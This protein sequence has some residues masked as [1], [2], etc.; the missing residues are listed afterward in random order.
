MLRLLLI[1]DS[2]ARDAR[3]TRVQAK[4]AE[5]NVTLAFVFVTGAGLATT[6]GSAFVFCTGLAN[7]KMLAGALGASAGVMLYVRALLAWCPNVRR[8]RD[9]L[10]PRVQR[11]VWLAAEDPGWVDAASALL[12]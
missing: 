8:G 12:V 11:V 1:A 2:A 10:H 7:H 6:I 5:G 3:G 4:V 9:L